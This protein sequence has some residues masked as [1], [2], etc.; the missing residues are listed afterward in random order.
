[1]G[2]SG[3]AV[4]AGTRRNRGGQRHEV[5]LFF[6]GACSG[7]A[8]RGVCGA[9]SLGRLAGDRASC[10]ICRRAR[11]QIEGRRW[12]LSVGVVVNTRRGWNGF[13][14]RG[15]RGGSRSGGGCWE[16]GTRLLIIRVGPSIYIW[17]L[18]IVR[19]YRIPPIVIRRSRIKYLGSPNKKTVTF[20][21]RL[22]MIRT[23][24]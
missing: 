10:S 3:L 2:C 12:M 14:R 6:Y 13:E 11:R 9:R 1:M 8:T 4:A 17:Q 23:Q 20:C 16:D 5:A 21:R 7:E 22:E 19:G 18:E 24:W 15:S